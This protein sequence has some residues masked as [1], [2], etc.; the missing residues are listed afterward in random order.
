VSARRPLTH[1]ATASTLL[2]V[3]L[4]LLG[5][6]ACSSSA[7]ESAAPPR[8]VGIGD[9]LMLLA[10]PNI[11]TALDEGYDARIIARNGQRIDQM[12]EPLAAELS[13]RRPVAAVVTNLGTNN[14]I[15]SST[16]AGSLDEFDRLVAATAPAPC[17]V[18]TTVSTYLDTSFQSD[19]AAKLNEKIRAL[20]QQDPDRFQIVD[21]D[22]AVHEPGG[23]ERLM[24]V[25]GITD[26]VHENPTAGRQWF[27]D[28]YDEALS[29]CPRPDRP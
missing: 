15:Q 5:L 12:L 3:V 4:L 25:D 28:Q 18:L 17:V 24:M 14:V 13:R 10:T 22:A 26:G 23:V 2:V 11:R 20:R 19:L 27:A 29:R 21:W 9:S 8:V 1:R 16:H 7:G 6:A